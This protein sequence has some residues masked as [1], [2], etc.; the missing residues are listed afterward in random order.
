M[1]RAQWPVCG[2]IGKRPRSTDIGLCLFRADRPFRL[3]HLEISFGICSNPEVSFRRSPD[4]TACCNKPAVGF[5]VR[6]FLAESFL[7]FIQAPSATS[8]PCRRSTHWF[9]KVGETRACRLVPS[10]ARS[11]SELL[12]TAAFASSLFPTALNFPQTM[13]R[14]RRQR[15]P[16][17]GKGRLFAHYRRGL[18]EVRS[19]YNNRRHERPMDA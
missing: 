18:S 5:L 3:G 7:P 11:K 14:P 13:D 4:E 8:F 19:D 2:V 17:Q 12:L 6:W 1:A 9:R 10:M 15:V 16:H